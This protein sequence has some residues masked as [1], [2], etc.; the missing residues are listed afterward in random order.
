MGGNGYQ[1][2]DEP[3]VHVCESMGAEQQET[4]H[5]DGDSQDDGQT[6]VHAVI[7]IRYLAS[8][9]PV[10]NR[11]AYCRDLSAQL[12]PTKLRALIAVKLNAKDPATNGRHPV[13]TTTT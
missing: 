10:T 11:N 3:Q 1:R 9:A 5:T 7:S 2:S 8:V 4:G 13:L 12:S 6:P